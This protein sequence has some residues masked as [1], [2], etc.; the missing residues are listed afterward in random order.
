MLP[1]TT[2]TI[3]YYDND[4]YKQYIVNLVKLIGQDRLTD[5]VHGSN[6]RIKFVRQQ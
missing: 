5:W 2:T 4:A 6:P 3:Y 1:R